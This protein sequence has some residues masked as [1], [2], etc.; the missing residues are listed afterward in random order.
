[1]AISHPNY[2]TFYSGDSA[3]RVL[4]ASAEDG[5]QKP[6]E[7]AGHKG[8]VVDIAPTREGNFVSAAYDDTVKTLSK[9]SGFG[10]VSVLELTI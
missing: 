5:A 8:Y 4:A 2:D 9:A 6:V 7:G 3:G 1:M 10:S